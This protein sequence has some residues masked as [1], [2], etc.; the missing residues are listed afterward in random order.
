MEVPLPG[1]DDG[2]ECTPNV[3]GENET[4]PLPLADR[5]LRYDDRRL[6]VALRDRTTADCWDS[7]YAE[8]LAMHAWRGR[9][10]SHS[11]IHECSS[12]RAG[13]GT[14][15]ALMS[16]SPRGSYEV[17]RGGL[18]STL[19]SSVTLGGVARGEGG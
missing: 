8:A 11:V 14:G 10:N 4:S 12:R 17:V 5:G 19:I 13:V 16:I 9:R 15:E 3:V 2:K 1:A 7:L 18:S 6:D